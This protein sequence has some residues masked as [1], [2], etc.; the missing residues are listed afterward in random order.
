MPSGKILP[1]VYSQCARSGK[2]AESELRSYGAPYYLSILHSVLLLS[3]FFKEMRLISET[4]EAVFIDDR[5][6]L[7]VNF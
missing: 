5:N 7:S 1:V 4:L 6:H 3:L 2:N